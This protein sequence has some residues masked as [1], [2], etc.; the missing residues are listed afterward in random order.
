MCARVT[1]A[2]G[3]PRG[4]NIASDCAWLNAE[5]TSCSSRGKASEPLRWNTRVLQHLAQRSLP[6]LGR[7]RCAIGRAH[8]M[9]QASGRVARGLRGRVLG[10][11]DP[12][13][14]TPSPKAHFEKKPRN[15]GRTTV[16]LTGPLV[17]LP[18]LD[19]CRPAQSA[20]RRKLSY[21]RRRT[22]VAAMRPLY[23]GSAAGV[24]RHDARTQ[25][26]EPPANRRPPAAR[27]HPPRRNL[28]AVFCRDRLETG[29]VYDC[30]D[31]SAASERHLNGGAA[32]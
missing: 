19:E 5:C 30:R 16:M 32:N 10:A 26:H 4:M 7:G 14:S 18:N 2:G 23:P 31:K 29:A 3:A 11:S 13:R 20:Q 28:R 24:R 6:L 12:D 15:V 1:A 9:K 27:P 21:P 8:P 17:V 25:Q 22:A